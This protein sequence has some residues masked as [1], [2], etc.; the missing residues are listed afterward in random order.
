M[1][2]RHHL[3]LATCLATSLA[4]ASYSQSSGTVTLIVADQERTIPVWSD[5]SD[6]SGGESWPSINI[7]AR[8]FSDS[9]EEPALISLSFE[10]AGW[11]PS[12][13][14]MDL[15]LYENRKS[16]G[17]LFA[18]EE[19]ERGGLTVIV[20]SHA[21]DGTSLSLSGSFEGTLGPSDNYGNDIDLSQGVP[22][23]GTFDVVLETLE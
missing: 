13:P 10:A 1:T 19:E 8:D 7:Y 23:T 6:W 4:T 21:F 3:V 22:V 15:V 17:R 11:Q 14:E 12:A 20:D 18:R 9:G 5:Q 16:V 2:S